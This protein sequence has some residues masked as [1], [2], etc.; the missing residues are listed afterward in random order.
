MPFDFI[1]WNTSGKDQFSNNKRPQSAMFPRSKKGKKKKINFESVL[2]MWIPVT[3]LNK[4]PCEGSDSHKSSAPKQLP[5][6]KWLGAWASDAFTLALSS[7]PKAISKPL[8]SQWGE[9]LRGQAWSEWQLQLGKGHI[10]EGHLTE[11]SSECRVCGV[12]LERK[13]CPARG[14]RHWEAYSKYYRREQNS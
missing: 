9:D 5:L 6:L 12:G 8:W 10:P 2:K 7:H 1:R 14:L 4:C 11:E 13:A 3:G